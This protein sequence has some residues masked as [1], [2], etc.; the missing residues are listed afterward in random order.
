MKSKTHSYIKKATSAILIPVMLSGCATY[1]LSDKN[2]QYPLAKVP[3]ATRDTCAVAPFSY[4]PTEQDEADLMTKED[5]AV[6]NKQFYDAINRADLCG[7]TIHLAAGNPSAK[8]DYLIDGTVTNFYFKKNWVPMF[9]P[10]WVGLTFITLGIYGLAAGPMTT[11]LV[12]FGYTVN[13][14]DASGKIIESI[15]EKFDSRDVQT[16]YS[17]PN[18]NPY[19]NPGLAFG[20]TIND[21]T[22]KLAEAISRV[23]NKSSGSPVDQLRQLKDQGVLSEQEYSEK[24]RKLNR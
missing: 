2:P 9:F 21:V 4:K 8:Y 13:L 6:W 15:P 19:G 18:D 16:L 23:D 7:R 17:D 20:P 14:K 10:G 1:R 12:D 3:E 11:S 22:K 24:L 5:L